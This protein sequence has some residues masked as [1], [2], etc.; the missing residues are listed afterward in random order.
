MTDCRY[1]AGD[2]AH[3]HG[4][5]IVHVTARPEC[6]EPDCETPEVAH[7]FTV[8]CIAVG[9]ACDDVAPGRRIAI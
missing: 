7:A 9:C 8:D 3:C 1:C 6:T 2:V 4:T 5:V